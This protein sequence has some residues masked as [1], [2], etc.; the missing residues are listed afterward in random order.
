[1]RRRDVE[2][3]CRRRKRK[4]KELKRWKKEKLL[5]C[6]KSKKLQGMSHRKRRTRMQAFWKMPQNTTSQVLFLKHR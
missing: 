1:M 2:Q 3:R 5:R 4:L 6:Q